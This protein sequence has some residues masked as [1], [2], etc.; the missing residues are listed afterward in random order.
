MP[1]RGVLAG[2][3]L[4]YLVSCLLAAWMHHTVVAALGFCAGSVLAA[5][6]SRPAALLRVV[7]AVPAIFAVAEVLAQLITLH[8]AARHSLALAVTGGTLLTL[9][10]VAP[11]LLA[12]TAGAVIIALFRGL[13]QCIGDLRAELRG[14]SKA[15]SARRNQPRGYHSS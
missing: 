6:Y 14:G 5:R 12:G 10:T 4:W 9:A 13:P 7:V 8:S 1:A 2:L 3:L 11:W 15:P